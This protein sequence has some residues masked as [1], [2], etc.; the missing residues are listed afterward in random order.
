MSHGVDGIGS[1]FALL[2]RAL[3]GLAMRQRVTA[4]NIANQSVPGYKR[5][6]VSFEDQLDRAARGGEFRPQVT[7]DRSGGGVDGNNVK[8]EKEVGVLTRIE[9]SYQTLS[10]VLGMDAGTVSLALLLALLFDAVIDPILG[11]L[12]DRTYSRWGRRQPGRFTQPVSTR[13]DGVCSGRSC[14]YR[15]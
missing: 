15:R 11:N 7:V 5:R 13:R 9:L 4:S 2:E 10:Q 12:S 3:D 14:V 6:T 1:Q 8:P